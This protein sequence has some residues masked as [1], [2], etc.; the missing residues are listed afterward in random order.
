MTKGPRL[1]RAGLCSSARSGFGNLARVRLHQPRAQS[2]NLDAAG[3]ERRAVVSARR[4]GVI[5]F[6]TSAKRYQPVIEFASG[7]EPVQ[8][9][10]RDD[11]QGAAFVERVG[12]QGDVDGLQVILGLGHEEQ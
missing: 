2:Q 8:L 12:R 9:R 3:L 5:Y 4:S 7:I 6:S 10:R 1:A 11:R